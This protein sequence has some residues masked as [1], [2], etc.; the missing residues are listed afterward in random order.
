MKAI[1]GVPA[2]HVDSDEPARHIA[3][4]ETGGAGKQAG[5]NFI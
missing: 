1:G 4:R 5:R 3:S 2:R